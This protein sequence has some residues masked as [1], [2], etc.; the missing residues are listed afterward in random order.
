MRKEAAG[1]SLTLE[2]LVVDE[3][4]DRLEQGLEAPGELQIRVEPT[5]LRKHFED[6]GEHGSTPLCIAGIARTD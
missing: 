6:H 2:A 5:F 4:I 1:A 3:A